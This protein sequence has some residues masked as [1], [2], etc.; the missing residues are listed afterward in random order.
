M[1]ISHIAAM[2]LTVLVWALNHL[3]VKIGVGSCP[4]LLFAAVR[5]S[6]VA[7]VLLPFS[8]PPRG[9][10]A[11]IGWISFWFGAVSLGLSS[12]SLVGIDAAT[13]AIVVNLG[14]PFSILAGR[15]AFGE[16]FGAWRWAG[17]ATS[18][19]GVALLAGEPTNVSPWY[20]V[21][22]V[23]SIGC[24]AVANAKIKSLTQLSAVTVN[25]WV[26]ALA[27]VQLAAASWVLEDHQVAALVN[28]DTQLVGAL[29]FAALA[30]SVIGHTLWNW[31][32]QRHP[33][34]TIAP[35]NLLVPF[36]GFVAALIVLDEPLTWQKAAGGL[37]AVAGVSVIQL[38]LFIQS[39]GRPA[40]P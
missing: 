25:G 38:R 14:T 3:A 20:F 7:L 29:L 4:P 10:W 15:I 36:V 34:S 21:A 27:A 22:A 8:S 28:A 19:V 18:F 2:M 13:S 11:A 17:V 16:K 24:W 37:L 30:S 31:L 23:V 35:F 32:L 26:S 12:I 6:I 33:I 9:A 5:L 39:R 1:P 40:A